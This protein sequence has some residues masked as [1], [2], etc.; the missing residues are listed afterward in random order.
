MVYGNLPILQTFLIRPVDE[1]YDTYHIGEQLSD[2]SLCCSYAH[3]KE[4]D[5]GPDQKLDLYN[6]TR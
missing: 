4:V 3:S 5:E 6:P 2:Q 1:I